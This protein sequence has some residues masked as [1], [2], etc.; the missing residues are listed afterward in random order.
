MKTHSF[1]NKKTD[2]PYLI[3]ISIRR[4]ASYT[5]QKNYSLFLLFPTQEP[6]IYTSL[7]TNNAWKV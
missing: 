2:L 5:G 6:K 7:D 4:V 3:L 1:K